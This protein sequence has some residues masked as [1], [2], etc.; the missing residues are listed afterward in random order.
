MLSQPRKLQANITD[1][2]RCK[3]PQQHF[4]KQNSGTHQKAHT[5]ESSWFIL[6]RQ[7]Y[8]YFNRGK[9]INVI[10]HIN[11]LKDKTM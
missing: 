3:N 6:G 2:H 11:K 7:G 8:I 9:S 4:N 10:H 5:P 1:E